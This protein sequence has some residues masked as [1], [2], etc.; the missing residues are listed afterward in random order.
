MLTLP[1]SSPPLLFRQC[2]WN[3]EPYSVKPLISP[4][5][6]YIINTQNVKDRSDKPLT[7]SQMQQSCPDE[8]YYGDKAEAFW[9]PDVTIFI[10]FFAHVIKV[11]EHI[12]KYIHI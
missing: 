3:T 7:F 11:R 6:L 4:E 12:M 8:T 10:A 2:C 1:C 9:P 5:P